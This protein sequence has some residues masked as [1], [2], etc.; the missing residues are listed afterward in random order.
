MVRIFKDRGITAEYVIEKKD[1]ELFSDVGSKNFVPEKMEHIVKRA[2][3]HL[4]A[5]IP[6]LPLSV[7]IPRQR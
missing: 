3:K 5:D 1:F 6:L 7:F 4:E 2:E